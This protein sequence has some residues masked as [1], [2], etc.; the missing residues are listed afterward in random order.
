MACDLFP[1]SHN[2]DDIFLTCKGFRVTPQDPI[3][4]HPMVKYINEKGTVL[5]TQE[6]EE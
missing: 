4:Y 5:T 3:Y 1:P 2:M 6:K